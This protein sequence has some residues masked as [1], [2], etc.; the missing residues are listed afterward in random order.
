[1][2]DLIKICEVVQVFPRYTAL[3]K[4]T[5]VAGVP[6]ILY[7]LYLVTIARPPLQQLFIELP[8][9]YVARTDASIERLTTPQ[10]HDALI[11][12]YGKSGKLIAV[13]KHTGDFR[14]LR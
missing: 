3:Q 6:F 13:H 4:V 9:D 7:F 10:A 11:S 8:L 5:I 2:I 1:M 12:V 14:E